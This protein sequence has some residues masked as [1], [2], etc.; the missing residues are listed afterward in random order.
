MN[1]MAS[2][3]VEIQTSPQSVPSTPSW[4]AEVAVVTHYLSTL[5]V[6][7]KIALEVRFAR[8]R[9]GIYDVIDFVCVL[10]GYALSGEPTL[11]AFYER[12]I[13]FATPF[14]ALFGR[15]KLPS[16]SA[17][18]RFLKALD[19][20]TVEALRTLFERDLVSRP[21]TEQEETTGGLWDRRGERWVVFDADG[22][23]QAARQ[24]ALPQTKDRPSAHRRMKGVC[25][26][27][28]TG[29]KRGEVVRTR[30][31]LAQ[32]HTHQWLGTF[33][34][35]GNGDYRG[36][37]L[38]AIAVISGYLTGQQLPL[39]RAILRLDGQYGDYAIVMD[40]DTSGLACVI[41]GKDYGLLDLPEIQAHLQRPPDEVSTHPETGTC[42][43]L[44]DCLDVP[45]T[46]MGPRIRV[47]VA[48]H[49]ATAFLAPI[50]ITRDGTVYELFFTALPQQ[51]FTPADV[52]DLYLHRGSFETVLCDEDKEQASDRWCSYSACGQE[53]WQILSQWMWNIR[54]ELGHRLHPTPMCTTEFAQAKASQESPAT[55]E[56]AAPVLESSTLPK[57]T[58]DPDTSSVPQP[59]N[60]L[61]L[62]A[63]GQ[64]SPS[65]L[66]YGAPE[67]ARTARE[68]IY[69]GRDFQPQ[70]DGTLRCPANHLL[71]PQERRAERDGTVRV[72]Y[73]ARIG[74]CRACPLREQCLAHGKETKHPRR[75]SAV[76]RAIEGPLP[77]PVLVPSPAPATQPILWGDWSR[78]QTRRKL[79]SLLRTQTV[80]ITL[81]PAAAP[82]LDAAKLGP[83][84]QQERKH[85][86]LAWEHRLARNANRAPEPRVKLHLF[87][88]PTVFAQS[89]G[90]LSV[91]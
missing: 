79:M 66:I 36:D 27:G 65:C 80:T 59:E 17:L 60:R 3:A 13:P 76:L 22:T 87:G 86:R 70:P 72:V 84:T 46:P 34:G 82:A 49:P 15:N 29:R 25:A 11:E 71:Y 31:T 20:S 67:W 50:G 91:A 33:G 1:S 35:S 75:V 9:F 38:R 54:L 7:E 28:Y 47:I 30:T 24:R 52:V 8:G 40:L 68:G 19:Q 2:S 81:T 5:G 48:T 16:R 85:Y 21:L 56:E 32:A 45:L 41:R 23:R 53:V 88:I 42:R 6:L 39:D 63:P 64:Q 74:D 43:A 77:A 69:A 44:F 4:L 73:A 57:D 10:I 51:A 55:S 58:S 61:V 12:L 26:A 18:S 90:L 78:C 83:F 62:A 89:I 37:L 14:M